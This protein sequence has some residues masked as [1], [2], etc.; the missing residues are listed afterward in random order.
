MSKFITFE[1][2][3]VTKIRHPTLF[4]TQN[5]LILINCGKMHIFAFSTFSYAYKIPEFGNSEIN[6]KPSCFY[7]KSFFTDSTCYSKFFHQFLL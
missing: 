2:I 4:R 3:L 1:I 5:I 7:P 6:S